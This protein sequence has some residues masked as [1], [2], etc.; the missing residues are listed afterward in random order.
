MEIK[1]LG[2]EFPISLFNGA[3]NQVYYENSDGFWWK[4]RYDEKQRIVYFENSYGRRESSMYTTSGKH[5]TNISSDGTYE[6]WEFDLDN[7]VTYKYTSRNNYWFRKKYDSN[8]NLIYHE[9]S[10]MHQKN[11]I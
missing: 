10:E 4:Q 2:M 7:R 5:I 6:L 11:V 1:D 3:G 8:G 9:N